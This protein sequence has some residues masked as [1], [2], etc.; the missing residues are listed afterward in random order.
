MVHNFNFIQ[1]KLK[2]LEEFNRTSVSKDIDH[3]IHEWIEERIRNL[4]TSEIYIPS[5]AL[6]GDYNQIKKFMNSF[7]NNNLY[8]DTVQAYVFN[9][10][11][12]T[13]SELQY[14]F[15]KGL[16]PF[17]VKENKMVKKRQWL[18][19]TKNTM[20][21]TM[22]IVEN[23]GTL[24][25][26]TINICTPITRENKVKAILCG[27]IK[28]DKIIEKIKRIHFPSN[29]YYFISDKYGNVLTNMNS[30]KRKI[31]KEIFVNNIVNKNILIY[32][33]INVNNDM[34][35]IKRF[36]HFD[37]YI[38]VKIDNSAINKKILKRFTT[39]SLM[40]FLFFLLLIVII[41]AAH[42]F[43]RRRVEKQK[44]EYEYI[45]AHRSRISEI[46]ELISGINHQLC[47][48]INSLT[49]LLSN[50]LL[51]KKQERLSNAILNENLLMCQKAT[52]LMSNTI[53]TFRNFYR[54]NDSITTFNLYNCI[55]SVLQVMNIDL[56]QNNINVKIKK[57]DNTI[58]IKSIENLVQQ[59][60]LVLLQNSKEAFINKIYSKNIII[61]VNVKSKFTYID[62]IDEAEGIQN[63]VI[64]K[65]F[66]NI[67]SSK[68]NL[69]SGIGLYFAKK[70]AKEK[71]GGDLI[72][73]KQSSPTIFRLSILNN[74][75]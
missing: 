62:I 23:H 64:D 34:I 69:G 48:P 25:E 45:L 17:H 15:K 46:G 41:N 72:L 59:I 54:C 71:L 74:L 12:Y 47:Q 33:T 52:K 38:G 53:M 19:K 3:T 60:L 13:N 43:L 20:K 66:S 11:F 40:L 49:L 1:S 6:K 73:I 14:D 8:F 28:V 57:L 10:Y 21:T 37:W 36:K 32:K 31:I 4:E 44:T 75:E 30:K 70:L 63:Q 39:N 5:N 65:L 35:S 16:S 24:F 42:E 2:I 67:K 7:L 58:D 22:T 9:Y 50:T 55:F 68:K 29:S 18:T 27:I 51:L 26:K 56:T 61:E